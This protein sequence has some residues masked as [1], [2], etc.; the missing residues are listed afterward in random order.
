MASSRGPA[1]S[2]AAGPVFLSSRKPAR[3]VATTDLCPVT[4]PRVSFTR[5]G[6]SV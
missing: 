2:R 1:A 3:V 4:G 6:T 5:T